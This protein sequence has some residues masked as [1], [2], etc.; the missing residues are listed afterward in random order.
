MDEQ[1]DPWDD[2]MIQNYIDGCREDLKRR[3]KEKREAEEQ[4]WD[5]I[6]R[7]VNHLEKS[8]SSHDFPTVRLPARWGRLAERTIVLN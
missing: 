1:T 7:Y 8:D 6:R 5:Q 2:P 4:K 3:E